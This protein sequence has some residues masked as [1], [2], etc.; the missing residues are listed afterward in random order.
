MVCLHWED[1][2]ASLD[3]RVYIFFTNLYLHVSFVVIVAAM[4][5]FA[6]LV[7]VSDLRLGGDVVSYGWH[8]I[9]SGL[10]H[11]HRLSVDRVGHSH[12]KVFLGDTGN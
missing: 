1:L 2:K 8:L 6:A 5:I 7:L 11:L 3:F 12:R 4:L 10:T 9:I